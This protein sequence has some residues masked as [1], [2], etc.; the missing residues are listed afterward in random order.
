MPSRFLDWVGDDSLAEPYF[1]EKDSQHGEGKPNGRRTS[2]RSCPLLSWICCIEFG[3][4]LAP[5][6]D[7]VRIVAVGL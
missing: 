6:I 3:A 4:I 7:I 1:E 5:G 2:D